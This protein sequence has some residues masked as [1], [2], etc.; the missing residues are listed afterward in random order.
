MANVGPRIEF[1]AKTRGAAPSVLLAPLVARPKPALELTT[2]ADSICD[3][4][5]S[6]LVSIGAL[7]DEAGRIAHSSRGG[8]VQRIAA[9]SLGDRDRLDNAT[10]RRAGAAAASWL[11]GERVAAAS[12]WIDGLSA[13]DAEDAV[14]EFA[15]GLLLGAY[16]FNEHRKLDDDDA[17]KLKIQLFAA[18][19]S[20]VERALKAIKQVSLLAEAVNDT[21]ALQQQPGNVINPATLADYCA[22]LATSSKIKCTVLA[23]AKL[24]Q[25]N[26]NGLLSVGQGA[27]EQSRLIQLEYRGAP[28]SRHVTVLVGKAITFD[29]GG[30]SIKPAANLHQMKYDKSGGC[31]VIGAIQAAAALK[32]PCNV[33]VLVAAAEN[34]VSE[35]AY[36]PGDIIRMANGKTVEITNTDAEG[37]MVLADALWYAETHCKATTIID[38]ATLTGGVVVSLGSVC[39]GLMSNNDELAAQL[40][41]SGRVTHERLWRLPLWSDYRELMK[42]VDA[43][44]VN[45][46]A[47]REAAPIQGGIFLHEFVDHTPWAHLD[48]AGVASTDNNGGKQGSAFGVRL[49]LNYL[50][51]ISR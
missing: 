42:G 13:T 24:K 34:M 50:Q 3:D 7:S 16:R 4:A 5:V 25:L 33:T 38:L 28:R 23:G 47:K 9:I 41:E 6:E 11:V 37:R 30:Y 46:S 26:M 44:L 49:L 14:A 31:I 40:E 43:D 51:R 18:N 8:R 20:H 35:G 32:L 19:A 39:A 15:L 1:V 22:K 17:D 27:A 12:L 48:I 36:R 2:R 29:T 21:R 10:L 45:S